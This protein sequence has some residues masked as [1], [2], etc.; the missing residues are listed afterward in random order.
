MPSLRFVEHLHLL[1]YLLNRPSVLF[2][3][4]DGKVNLEWNLNQ[5]VIYGKHISV[6]LEHLDPL[7]FLL[8]FNLGPYIFNLGNYHEPPLL[9][10]VVHNFVVVLKCLVEAQE[11]VAVV[12]LD[13]RPEGMHTHDEVEVLLSEGIVEHFLYL[14]VA[15]DHF[16]D[17]FF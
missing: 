14:R 17:V 2:N 12:Q 4:F 5:L 1:S 6:L 10:E 3:G 15:P 7:L 8:Y 9:F 11:V 16:I 13:Q